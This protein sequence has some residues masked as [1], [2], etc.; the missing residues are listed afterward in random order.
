MMLARGLVRL[1][2]GRVKE[3]KPSHGVF[4]ISKGTF[5]RFFTPHVMSESIGSIRL[6]GGCVKKTWAPCLV[7]NHE[8]RSIPKHFMEH[9]HLHGVGTP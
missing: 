7:R 8:P 6:R 3:K 4:I 5:L 1:A 9:V 2:T